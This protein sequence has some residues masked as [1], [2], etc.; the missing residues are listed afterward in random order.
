MR[1]H[2]A[3]DLEAV[4]RIV[5]QIAAGLRSF[6]RMEML[7]QDLRP[8]NVMIDASGTVRIID[9]GSVRVA[10]LADADAGAGPGSAGLGTLSHAAPET[11]IGERGQ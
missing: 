9:F 5:E 7:H 1:D 4:R 2:P 8:D 11:F 10:G 3:C 6:H